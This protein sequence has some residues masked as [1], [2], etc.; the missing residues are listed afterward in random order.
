M[1][2]GG[3]EL[4]LKFRIFDGTDIGHGSYSSSVTVAT[5]K[6][7]LLSQWPQGCDSAFLFVHVL[8]CP[9]TRQELLPLE[10]CLL[11]AFYLSI[12]VPYAWFFSFFFSYL[13]KAATIV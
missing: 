2:E 11:E 5:L 9:C 1:A 4:E 3:E 8:L 6:Q 7:R 13:R 10:T 12:V